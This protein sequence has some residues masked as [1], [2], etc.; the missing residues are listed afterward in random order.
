MMVRN[1]EGQCQETETRETDTYSIVEDG[2]AQT[3]RVRGAGQRQES[4]RDTGF[5]LTFQ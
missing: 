3:Q 2:K 5:F 1:I 4:H